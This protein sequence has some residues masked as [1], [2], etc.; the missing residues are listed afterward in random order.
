MRP[1]CEWFGLFRYREWLFERQEENVA[2]WAVEPTVEL[3]E[4]QAFVMEQLKVVEERIAR[5]YRGDIK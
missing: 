3:K 4:R 5:I 1:N 2:E